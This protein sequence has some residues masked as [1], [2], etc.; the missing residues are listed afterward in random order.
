MRT[1]TRA[2]VLILCLVA[3][4]DPQKVEAKPPIP[5]DAVSAPLRYENLM[6]V[7]T[8]RD[9]AAAVV[10]TVRTPNSAR[11]QY[12]YESHDGKKK[13]TGE[14]K[15]TSA[16]RLIKA[17]PIKLYWSSAVSVDKAW[18][19]YRPE[20]VRVN[21]AH[22]KY[23]QDRFVRPGGADEE[24]VLIKRLDLKRFMKRGVAGNSTK[25]SKAR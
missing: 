21:M 2:V 17:G 25:K 10:F 6:L 18:I 24:P 14:G 23:F 16:T 9:G 8:S 12:R 5:D 13:L 3:G 19:Y 15:V 7:L 22:A 1:L 20:D 4:S 11:F